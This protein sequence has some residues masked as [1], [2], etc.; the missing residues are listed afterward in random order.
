MQIKLHM[1]ENVFEEG[2][3]FYIIH[4]KLYEEILKA[5]LWEK[6]LVP[7]ALVLHYRFITVEPY[8]Y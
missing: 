6:I 5:K 1:R 8:R 3:K 2:F 4:H 7:Y